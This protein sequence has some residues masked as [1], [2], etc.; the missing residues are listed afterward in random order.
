MDYIELS[1]LNKILDMKSFKLSLSREGKPNENVIVVKN[2]V[3]NT[4]KKEIR[5]VRIHCFT[6]QQISNI[7]GISVCQTTMK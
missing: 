5:S 1:N 6:E 7:K 4:S 2:R 3:S